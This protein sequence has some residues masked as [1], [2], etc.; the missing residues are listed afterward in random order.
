MVPGLPVAAV[1]ELPRDPQP[2]RALGAI[3]DQ[4]SATPSVTAISA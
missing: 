1:T 2:L 3:A 4:L